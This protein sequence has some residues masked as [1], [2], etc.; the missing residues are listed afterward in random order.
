MIVQR[1]GRPCSMFARLVSARSSRDR[2]VESVPDAGPGLEVEEMH[3]VRRDSRMWA[4]D[5]GWNRPTALA[6]P[7]ASST[8]GSPEFTMRASMLKCTMISDPSDS[9]SVTTDVR[10]RPVVP[11]RH[12]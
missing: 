6:V 5:L 3:V 11:R 1:D 2:G 8:S 9:T 4:R 10:L 7:P 12:V